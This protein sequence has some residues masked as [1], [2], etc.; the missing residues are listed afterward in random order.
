VQTTEL[1]LVVPGT[2]FTDVCKLVSTTSQDHQ[3][4]AYC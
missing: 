4:L 3:Q 2:V 1:V